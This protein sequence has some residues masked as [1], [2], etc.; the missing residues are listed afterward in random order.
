VPV[1]FTGGF[2]QYRDGRGDRSWQYRHH[3]LDEFMRRH[4][5]IAAS[6][7]ERGFNTA[8]VTMNPWTTTETAFD[9]GF[10]EFIDLEAADRELFAD[11]PLLQALDGVFESQ[12]LSG[13]TPWSS[14]RYWFVQWEGVY[15][16]VQNVLEQLES[17]YFCWVFLLD[18]H[19]PYISPRR[20]RAEGSTFDTLSHLYRYGRWKVGDAEITNKGAEAL[21]RGYR[22]TVRSVDAFL[23]QL[24]TDVTEHGDEPALVIHSDHGEGLGEHGTF[25][26]QRQ[27]YEQ[28]LRVPLVVHDG[29]GQDTVDEPVSL[30]SLPTVLKTVSDDERAFDPREVTQRF[31][32]SQTEFGDRVALR[33]QRFKYVRTQSGE[34]LYDLQADPTERK[35]H[36]AAAPDV[37]RELSRL[38]DARLADQ[39]ERRGH[40]DAVADLQI[41]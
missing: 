17:P 6:F 39:H 35:D 34:R 8:A 40:Y 19:L 24:L 4:Q 22:D 28:N 31:T 25:S 36:S 1:S 38:L 33:G 14:Q 10:D 3:R 2:H 29:T 21:E 26:H 18:C 5:S 30:R 23:D 41:G 16:L 37:C 13:R 32:L 7:R 11:R 20:L 27:L 15:P 9:R 12:A